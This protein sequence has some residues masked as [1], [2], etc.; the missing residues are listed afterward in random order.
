MI[1]TSLSDRNVR[2]WTASNIELLDYRISVRKV[3]MCRFAVWGSCVKRPSCG[4]QDIGTSFLSPAR[5]SHG[6]SAIGL[7]LPQTDELLEQLLWPMHHLLDFF[8]GKDM[9]GVAQEQRSTR[10]LTRRESLISPTCDLHE[11]YRVRLGQCEKINLFG[12]AWRED[13]AKG[14]SAQKFGDCDPQLCLR[15]YH[16]SL[17]PFRGRTILDQGQVNCQPLAR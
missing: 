15:V 8:L 14:S 9:D 13:H 12:R 6:M 17:V 10:R 1:S 5:M 2:C 11:Q 3:D 7:S 4:Q 16:C